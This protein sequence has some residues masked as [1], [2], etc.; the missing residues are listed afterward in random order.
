[1]DNSRTITVARNME[2]KQI[3]TFFSST[4][5]VLFVIFIFVFEN[6]QNS[7][8]C[9]FPFGSFWSV[10]Y[11]NLGQ[12]LPIRTTN[13]TFIESRHPEG[14]KNPYYVLYTEWSQKK[15]ISSWTM[16]ELFRKVGKWRQTYKQTSSTI[17]KSN[18]VSNVL[19]SKNYL[20]F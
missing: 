16:T 8:S 17:H 10:R 2:N 4:F 3:I 11:L 12:K 5:S 1:M 6:S 14:T 18:D 20:K 15:G 13:H 19:R 7:F 9:S